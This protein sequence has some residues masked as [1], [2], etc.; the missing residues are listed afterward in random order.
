MPVLNGPVTLLLITF[1]SEVYSVWELE[2]YNT[3]PPALKQLLLRVATGSWKFDLGFNLLLR[4]IV[5]CTKNND[6][7]S[8]FFS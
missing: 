3:D 8:F 7:G 2:E 4:P 1:L 6:P 5:L